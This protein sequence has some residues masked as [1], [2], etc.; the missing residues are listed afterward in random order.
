[1]TV[2]SV[3]A[4]LP[5]HQY[6]RLLGDLEKL[7]KWSPFDSLELQPSSADCRYNNNEIFVDGV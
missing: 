6:L 4:K 7:G 3:Q 2:F 1:M 5:S